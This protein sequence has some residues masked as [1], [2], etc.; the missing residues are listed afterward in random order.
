M[1]FYI[2]AKT[3]GYYEGDRAHWRD[4]A[5]MQRP[6]P[7]YRWVDG[8]WEYVDPMTDPVYAAVEAAKTELLT[9]PLA[10]VTVQ[11]ALAAVDAITDPASIRQHMRQQDRAILALRDIVKNMLGIL[12]ES[13]A[14]TEAPTTEA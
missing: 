8:G 9:G 13:M 5:V 11:Q 6:G 3:G 12:Q 1:G 2:S 14:T 10:T 7:D 4:E